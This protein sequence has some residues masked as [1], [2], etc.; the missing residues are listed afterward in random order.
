[1]DEEKFLKK[2]A[3]LK[4]QL[5]K[6]VWEASQELVARE[7][8]VDALFKQIAEQ[9]TEWGTAQQTDNSEVGSTR[10]STENES[11]TDKSAEEFEEERIRKKTEEIMK[12]YGLA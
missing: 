2:L 9:I 5:L 3:E 4:R 8:E 6:L 11:S 1:M 7:A 10:T 12:E